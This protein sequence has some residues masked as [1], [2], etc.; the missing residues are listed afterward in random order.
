LLEHSND[1][2]I[3]PAAGQFYWSIVMIMLSV[4]IL[5]SFVGAQR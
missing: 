3:S 2:A 4:L 1:N 5:G